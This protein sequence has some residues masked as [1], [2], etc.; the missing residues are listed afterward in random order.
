MP[1][2]V[3]TAKQIIWWYG[4]MDLPYDANRL[5]NGNTL[6]SDSRNS[7]VIEVD[8]AGLIVWEYPPSQAT[9]SRMFLPIITK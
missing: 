5:V 2:E 6:I 3:T 7:R 9:P 1:I 8:S 4:G